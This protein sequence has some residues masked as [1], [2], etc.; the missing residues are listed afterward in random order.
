MKKVSQFL[1]D[2]LTALAAPSGRQ[3]LSELSHKYACAS[4]SGLK[5]CWAS[6]CLPVFGKN[7]VETQSNLDALA[8]G[9]K[10]CMDLNE[11]F[12]KKVPKIA[13]GLG[14]VAFERKQGCLDTQRRDVNCNE[15]VQDPSL[16]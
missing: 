14:G 3:E 13:G 4:R 1:R 6:A 15:I 5:Q 7:V 9:R 2:P 10:L 8:H 12:V 16:L 11:R